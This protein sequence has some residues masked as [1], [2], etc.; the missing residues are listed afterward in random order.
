M[1]G[2]ISAE[3]IKDVP[4]KTEIEMVKNI[5]RRRQCEFFKVKT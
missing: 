2:S 5:S 4:K 1:F 3:P